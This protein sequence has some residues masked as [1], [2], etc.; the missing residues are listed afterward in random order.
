[1]SSPTTAASPRCPRRPGDPDACA[2]S[3]R[4]AGRPPDVLVHGTTVAT[5]ALLERRLG[6][7]A[8]VTTRGFADVHRD[9]APGAS[10]AVR[11]A[12]RP[13]GA[14]GATRA[15]LRG[16]RADST[17]DGRELEAVRRHRTRASDLGP[18]DAV[19]VCLLHADLDPS[20]ERGVAAVLREHGLRRRLLA[21]GVAGVPRVRA[22]GDHGG[23]CRAALGVR[24]RTSA[25]LDRRGAE[26][27]W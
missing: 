25:R 23:R 14:A 7:V 11:R 18:V 19:A 21:R 6:R 3:T 26:S 13:A 17:R 27:C 1:M 10:V 2:S 15:A 4:V 8:L 9:R 16:R 20:H 5:N 24:T 22:H 12:R